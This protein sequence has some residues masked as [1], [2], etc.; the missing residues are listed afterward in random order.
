MQWKQR[1]I[2]F[3][4]AWNLPSVSPPNPADGPRGAC[5][6][7]GSIVRRIWKL[8]W[9]LPAEP[10]PGACRYPAL[11]VAASHYRAR[12]NFPALCLLQTGL[13]VVKDVDILFKIGKSKIVW[14]HS[15]SPI[16]PSY[17]YPQIY[18]HPWSSVSERTKCFVP[19]FQLHLV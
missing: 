12:T 2:K 15:C 13:A 19:W 7:Q 4:P 9:A 1:G 18:G 8:C 6:S 10:H 17:P 11:T 5:L 3:K 16:P 14:S